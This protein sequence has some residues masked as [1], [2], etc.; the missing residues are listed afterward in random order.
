MMFR[1]QEGI[2]RPPRA[3]RETE[4]RKQETGNLHQRK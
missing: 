4:E 1:S 2:F 3:L